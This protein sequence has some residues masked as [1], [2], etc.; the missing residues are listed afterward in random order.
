M[1]P[2]ILFFIGF[3]M[4]NNTSA[5]LPLDYS[6]RFANWTKLLDARDN[7]AAEAYYFEKIMPA[8]LPMMRAR[9]SNE[10]KWDGL[11]SLLGFTPETV[12]LTAHLIEPKSIL[13]MHT[14]ETENLIGTVKKYLPSYVEKIESIRF[15]HDDQNQDDIFRAFNLALHK[16]LA[17][18]SK[19]WFSC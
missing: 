2:S 19:V 8:I 14:K 6:T 7:S 4:I 16:L 18:N 5:L 17:L 15:L 3:A 1:F 13:I 11:V 10:V 9:M 12:V